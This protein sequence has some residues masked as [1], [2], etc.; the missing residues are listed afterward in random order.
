MSKLAL[1]REMAKGTSKR[2]THGGR[3][4]AEQGTGLSLEGHLPPRKIAVE[5]DFHKPG[6]PE[7]NVKTSRVRHKGW[8]FTKGKVE[9]GEERV[10]AN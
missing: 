5:D 9:K 7:R 6:A 4:W 2:L 1:I 8:S 10:T 3:A